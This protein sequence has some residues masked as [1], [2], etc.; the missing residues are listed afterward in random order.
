[1]RLHNGLV[2]TMFFTLITSISASAEWNV[3]DY[4]ADKT[5]KDDNTAA[6]QKALDAA[7]EAKG[8]VVYV[9][10]GHYKFTGHL[11]VPG[12]VTLRGT[13]SSAPHV[14]SADDLDG[15]VLLP[16]A[17]RNDA[18]GSPFI[19]MTT[20]S[21]LEGFIIYYKDVMNPETNQP[22]VYPP[23]I[24][25]STITWPGTNNVVIR[26]MN[27]VNAY[28]AVNL[29]WSSRVFISDI[30]GFPIH[31]GIYI[32]CCFDSSRFENIHWTHQGSVSDPYER[33]TR[34]NGTAFEFG[35]DD[36]QNVQHS[37]CRGYKTGFKF[38]ITRHV[39]ENDPAGKP[40]IVPRWCN[41]TFVGCG[42]FDCGNAIQVNYMQ[43]PGLMFTNCEFTGSDDP[44]SIPVVVS[45][46]AG[47]ATLSF[48]NC[49]FRDTGSAAILAKSPSSNLLVANSNF[50]NW[51]KNRQSSTAVCIQVDAGKA[52][53]NGN[54]FDKPKS[55]DHRQVHIGPE[56]KTAL[57]TGN[58]SSGK[59]SFDNNAG[60]KSI[61]KDNV[62]N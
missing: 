38:D 6:F 32:D 19:S 33:W 2:L 48:T 56:V 30:Q 16:T 42:A 52:I 37:F 22:W 35:R 26:H 1:M 14:S 9:P 11:T 46:T 40:L 25:P 59:F 7:S 49:M 24:Q 31:S 61:I 60:E 23:C 50:S 39:P 18:A 8:G 45:S 13:F 47:P 43:M 41:G 34:Q 5:G 36:F 15:S 58:T 12:S 3:M 54:T 55:Q 29:V 17:D 53:I 57:V 21:T 4:G 20:N 28:D 27:I 44:A 10:A 62:A 51:G